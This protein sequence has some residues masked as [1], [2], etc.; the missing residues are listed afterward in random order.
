MNHTVVSCGVDAIMN[1][2]GWDCRSSVQG[3]G[4]D[5]LTA[6]GID[7]KQ[8]CVAGSCEEKT[9]VRGNGRP[10]ELKRPEREEIMF[11]KIESVGDFNNGL[12]GVSLEGVGGQE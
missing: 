10:G 2:N 8:L 11:D 3:Q 5:D 7:H 6:S 4:V 9:S 12:S 1:N